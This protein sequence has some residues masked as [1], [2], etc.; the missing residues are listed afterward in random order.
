M[1]DAIQEHDGK[2]GKKWLANP[3]SGSAR[4]RPGLTMEEIRLRAYQR[5]QAAG[6]PNGDATKF[7]LQA[8]QELLQSRGS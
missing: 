2:D 4:K 1:P 6:K 5:W 3:T 8:E 7:W